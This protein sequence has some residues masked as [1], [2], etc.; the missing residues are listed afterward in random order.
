MRQLEEQIRVLLDRIAGQLTLDQAC[1]MG[2]I[3]SL[4]FFL[5]THRNS[6]AACPTKG[7]A[8]QPQRRGREC[9]EVAV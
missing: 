2:D 1:Q 4:T 8:G 5:L 3:T 7:S 9:D 6:A